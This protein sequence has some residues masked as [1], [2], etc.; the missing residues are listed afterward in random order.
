VDSVEYAQDPALLDSAFT[1]PLLQYVVSEF[2]EDFLPE[3]LG[4]T[5][6]FEWES[7]WLKTIIKMFRKQKIDLTFYQAHLAIDNAAEGH[8]ALATRAVQR[9]LADFDGDELQLRWRRIWDGYVA[10]REAGTLF[11]DLREKVQQQKSKPDKEA[12]EAAVLAMIERKKQ[13]GN[14]NHG[15]VGGMSNDLFDDPPHLLRVLRDEDNDL[16]VDG[17]PDDSRLLTL[18]TIEGPMYKVFTEDEQAL[19]RQWIE[20]LAP[21]E[22]AP[23]AAPAPVAPAGGGAPRRRHY[24]RLLHSTSAEALAADPRARLRGRGGV[25]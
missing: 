3:I 20:S 12:I 23:A 21:P 8:G 4:M 17:K 1:V 16:V 19:W 9:Y 10:F 24:K 22:D 25:Q 6:H 14:L 18:F 11:H 15:G 5:L 2:T 7:V 13:Y